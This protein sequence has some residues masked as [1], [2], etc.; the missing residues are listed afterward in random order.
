MPSKKNKT[1]MQKYLNKTKLKDS[2]SN[3]K[4]TK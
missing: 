3:K 1:K 4:Q 2:S